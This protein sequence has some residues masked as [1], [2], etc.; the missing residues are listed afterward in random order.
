[1]E[2]ELVDVVAT[3]MPEQEE[4]PNG[5]NLELAEL[6]YLDDEALWQAAR[7]RLAAQMARR[8]AKLHHKRQREGLTEIEVRTLADL[9]RQYE[10]AVLIRVQAAVLLKQR[11]HDVSKLIGAG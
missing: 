10:R 1:M 2:A 8:T 6:E 3:A 5:L 9:V 11:G 4:L 7:S